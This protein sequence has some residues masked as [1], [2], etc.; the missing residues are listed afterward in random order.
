VL[1][2]YLV[3]TIIALVMTMAPAALAADTPKTYGDAMRWYRAEAEKGYPR[4][5]FMLG[6]MYEVGERIARDFARAR[7]WYAKAAAQGETEAQ[8]RLAQLYFEGLGGDRDLARAARLYRAAAEAGHV[9][10]QSV[11]GYLYALGEGV[12]ADPM[13]AYLWLSLA[14]DAGDPFAAENFARLA[15][16][17]SA[18][19]IAAGEDKV[20]RW[21][22]SH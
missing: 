6:Y 17:L 5:Q 14:T 13:A 12:A 15:E 21:R 8:Y 7:E 22:A 3:M 10:A 20:R 9:G 4:A 19:Q 1:R 2:K 11:L 18:D 16:R